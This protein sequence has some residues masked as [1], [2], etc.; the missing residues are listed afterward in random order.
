MT[1]VRVFMSLRQFNVSAAVLAVGLALGLGGCTEKTST[2]LVPV[3][4]SVTMDGKPLE[5]ASV[6]FVGTGSTPGLGGTGVTDAAGNFEISHFR[7][8]KG[9]EQG[10]YKVMISKLVMSDG[11]PIPPGTLSIAELSTREM[12]PARYSDPG[13]TVLNA[14]VVEGGDPVSLGLASR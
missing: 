14:T 7:A 13:K 3:T 1:S 10:D 8:G 9:L 4:G 6:T 2:N 12:L 11:S 5:G